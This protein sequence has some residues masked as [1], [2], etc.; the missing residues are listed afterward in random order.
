M[1]SRITRSRD[2][3]LKIAVYEWYRRVRWLEVDI[4]REGKERRPFT[5]L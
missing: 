5:I 3:K 4:D 2:W 1:K